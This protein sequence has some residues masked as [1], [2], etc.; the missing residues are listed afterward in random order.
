M[1]NLQLE[2]LIPFPSEPA[3]HPQHEPLEEPLSEVLPEDDLLQE[4]S[5]G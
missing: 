2:N 5:Q 1:L 4:L 3:T